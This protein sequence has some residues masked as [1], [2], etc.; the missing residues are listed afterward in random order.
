MEAAR[1]ITQLENDIL[2]LRLPA[3]FRFKRVE[4]IVMPIDEAVMPNE[5]GN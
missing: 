4:V 5:Y 2:T 3:S 1:Q